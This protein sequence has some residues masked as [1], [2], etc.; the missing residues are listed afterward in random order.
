MIVTVTTPAWIDN[1]EYYLLEVS[2]VAGA[3]ATTTN[4]LA[5]VAYYTMRA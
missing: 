1:D 2:I 4:V 3:G 5:A